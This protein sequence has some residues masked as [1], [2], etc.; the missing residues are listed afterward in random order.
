MKKPKGALR[1]DYTEVA[2]PLEINDIAEYRSRIAYSGDLEIT[3]I[4]LWQHQWDWLTRRYRGYRSYQH[5][6]MY[7][8]GTD[9][10]WKVKAEPVIGSGMIMGIPVRIKNP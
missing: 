2:E 3:E 9:S 6:V 8:V 4:L 10:Q 1:L 7:A 5:S